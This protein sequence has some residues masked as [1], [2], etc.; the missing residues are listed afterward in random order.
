[1]GFPGLA[2]GRKIQQQN[3]FLTLARG[4]ETRRKNSFP[5]LREEDVR[6][7]REKFIERECE[8][9][10]PSLKRA[11]VAYIAAAT[12]RTEPGDQK[13]LEYEQQYG[14]FN[15]KMY[16]KNLK[17]NEIDLN[18][19]VSLAVIAKRVAD[20]DTASRAHVIAQERVAGGGIGV[21]K[22]KAVERDLA[23]KRRWEH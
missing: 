10:C 15:A 13:V 16:E 4:R 3:G 8:T 6:I 22:L 23:K 1:M 9:G 17:Q 19:G 18:N 2:K 7:G 12:A 21:N 5:N 11:S 14:G 20:R